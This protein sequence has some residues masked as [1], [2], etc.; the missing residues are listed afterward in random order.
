MKFL[1]AQ[2]DARGKF[3]SRCINKSKIL[4]ILMYPIQVELYYGKQLETFWLFV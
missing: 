4:N 1:K 3:T 2:A